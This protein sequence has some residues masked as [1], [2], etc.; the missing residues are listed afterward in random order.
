MWFE[1][2]TEIG[3]LLEDHHLVVLGGDRAGRMRLARVLADHLGTQPDTAVAVLDGAAMTDMAA[4]RDMLAARLG[5]TRPVDASLDGLLDLLREPADGPR[6]RHILWPD[7]DLVLETDVRLFG[8]LAGA[9][10]GVAAEHEHVS[11]DVLLLQRVV[12]LGGEKLGAYADQATGE[13][14]SWLTDGDAS[15]FAEVAARLT[16]PPVIT[17]RLDG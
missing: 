15:P 4:S 9:L 11:P 17:Y 2:A 13:L 5:A 10:L 14:Q 3:Q 8:R 7:A 16:R 6:R 12:F 1:V